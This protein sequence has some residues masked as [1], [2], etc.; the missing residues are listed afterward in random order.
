M[1][2]V[3]GGVGVALGTTTGALA[4]GFDGGCVIGIGGVVEEGGFEAIVVVV[5]IL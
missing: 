1:G 3:A 2:G 4:I 5:L